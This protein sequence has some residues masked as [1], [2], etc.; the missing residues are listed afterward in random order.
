MSSNDWVTGAF[1]TAL[2][3]LGGWIL[4]T[5]NSHGNSLA[6]IQD[7]Q[8]STERSV[9]DISKLVVDPKEGLI[10]KFDALSNTISAQ[11]S[12]LI[13]KLDYLHS[14]FTDLQQKLTDI[15]TQRDEETKTTQKALSD[16]TL[17]VQKIDNNPDK[18]PVK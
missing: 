7:H 11:P 3:G 16:L 10:P 5:V 18:T 9:G 13:P 2:L 8:A 14:R 6:V 17:A 1:G 12:G 15:Q 4:V